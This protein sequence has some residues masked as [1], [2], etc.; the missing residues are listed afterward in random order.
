MNYS[1]ACPSINKPNI[2]SFP[3]PIVGLTKPVLGPLVVGEL[4]GI[5]V[6]MAVMW[7]VPVL[8]ISVWL[9]TIDEM[10]RWVAMDTCDDWLI[11]VVGINCTL[12]V[13]GE[14]LVGGVTVGELMNEVLDE[15]LMWGVVEWRTRLVEEDLLKVNNVISALY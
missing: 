14:W 7:V 6:L 15:W 3:L 13:R 8:V 5:F 9:V 1:L 12:V 10:G 4:T 2:P 11:N